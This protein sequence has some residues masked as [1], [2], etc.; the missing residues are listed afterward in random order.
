MSFEKALQLLE[1][2]LEAKTGKHLTLVEKEILEAAWNNEPYN[3]IANSLHL[4]IGHIKDLAYQLWQRL[5]NLLDRK[6][7][8]NNFRNLLLEQIDTHTLTLEEIE[9]SDICQNS[10]CKGNVLIVDDL[11][12]NLKVLTEILIQQGYK[13]RSVTNAQM[14]LKTIDHNPPDIILLDIKMPEIDGYQVCKALKA[15]PETAEIPIVFLSALDETIDKVKAFQIGGVDYITKPFETEEV[16]ARIQSQLTI[17][18]QKHQLRL[19]IEQHQQ[20]TEILYQSRA[21]LASVLNSSL[22]GIAAMQAV[23]DITTGEIEDFRYL[24]VNPALAKLFGKKRE[25][26]MGKFIE[27]TLINQLIPK[28]FNLLVQVV[29]TGEPLEQEFYWDNNI[30]ELC[31]LIII[32]LADGCSIT[33]RQITEI[34][35]HN[36]EFKQIQQIASK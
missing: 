16:I 29:E 12:E 20:T 23:R 26:L 13:I 22:D 25:D 34:R 7:V 2:S 6:I 5:S 21:L 9:E 35:Q 18:Q 15:D 30:H 1:A 32:K 27:K 36:S 24:V 11:I 33:V 10:N 17:Q 4:S 14:A 8:K 19:E 31:Y 3:K 28:L